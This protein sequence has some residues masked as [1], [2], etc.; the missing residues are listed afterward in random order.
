[1]LIT[2][3]FSKIF[4]AYQ[5][6]AK[7][8]RAGAG[9][10]LVPPGEIFGRG[11]TTAEHGT[12][13][14]TNHCALPR[15]GPDVIIRPHDGAAGPQGRHGSCRPAPASSGTPVSAAENA[16]PLSSD[17]HSLSRPGRRTSGRVLSWKALTRRVG[18]ATPESQH[19]FL[20][21]VQM[22]ESTTI[23][24]HPK[25]LFRYCFLLSSIVSDSRDTRICTRQ[26]TRKI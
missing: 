17:Q 23:P 25:V 5:R 21:L 9:R 22:P 13:R 26:L 12:C 10:A 14:T 19:L 11:L 18:G 7:C 6:V 3:L 16:R 4:S 15:K 8:Y 1:M 24:G 2:H 20:S